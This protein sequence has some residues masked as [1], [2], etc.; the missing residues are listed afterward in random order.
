MTLNLGFKVAAGKYSVHENRY[1]N[2][3]ETVLKLFRAVSVICFSFY[4]RTCDWLKG[5]VFYLGGECERNKLP[6][7][8][9]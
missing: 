6:V 9:N 4:M 8:Y 3:A 2:E 5:D 7:G 1:A